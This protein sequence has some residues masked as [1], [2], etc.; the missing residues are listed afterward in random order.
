MEDS[1]LKAEKDNFKQV[2]KQAL[3]EKKGINDNDTT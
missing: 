1:F 3:K 2:I